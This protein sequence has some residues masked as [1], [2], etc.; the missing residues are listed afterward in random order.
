MGGRERHTQWVAQHGLDL[1]R[2]SRSKVWSSRLCCATT[3]GGVCPQGGR[4]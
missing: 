4:P 2:T 3:A 1:T